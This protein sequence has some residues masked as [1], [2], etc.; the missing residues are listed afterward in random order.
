M[1]KNVSD[2]DLQRKQEMLILAYTAG[3][4]AP[5][6]GDVRKVNEGVEEA[7]Y[8]HVVAYPEVLDLPDLRSVI[9]DCQGRVV[10]DYDH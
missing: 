6:T 10:K 2:P 7:G 4:P 8:Q 9:K 3:S 1:E 5:L